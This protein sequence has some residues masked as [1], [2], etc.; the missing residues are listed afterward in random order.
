MCLPGLQSEGLCLQRNRWR[1]C[2]SGGTGGGGGADRGEELAGVKVVSLEEANILLRLV[3][4]SRSS[5]LVFVNAVMELR[6]PGRVKDVLV[7]V[8]LIFSS[9]VT[10]FI[11]ST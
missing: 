4:V 8:G 3:A 7:A 9:K 10:I 1:G 11:L 6:W 2:Q 5:P